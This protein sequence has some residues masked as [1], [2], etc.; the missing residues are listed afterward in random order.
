MATTYPVNTRVATSDEFLQ[1]KM[2]FFFDKR[3]V[4]TLSVHYELFPGSSLEAPGKHFEKKIMSWQLINLY[5]RLCKI[6]L[7]NFNKVCYF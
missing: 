7:E 2:K 3:Y 4:F 1:P 6:F 5:S